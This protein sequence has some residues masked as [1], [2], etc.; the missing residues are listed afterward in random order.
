MLTKYLKYLPIP[1]VRLEVI[2]H[3]NNIETYFILDS[4]ATI[5]VINNEQVIK[6]NRYLLANS[7]PKI[8]EFL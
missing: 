7:K 4:D 3:I 1:G 5:S 8:L 2:G 6:S